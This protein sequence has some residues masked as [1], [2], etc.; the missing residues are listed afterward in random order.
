MDIQNVLYIHDY[1]LK[2]FII[3][4]L[5]I[6]EWITDPIRCK[7]HDL[8]ISIILFIKQMVEMVRNIFLL[9]Q[10]MRHRSLLDRS[11]HIKFLLSFLQ[12]L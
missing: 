12:N 8:F 4:F 3:C 7:L 1:I 11:E 2:D 10:K 6:Y 9:G 5:F